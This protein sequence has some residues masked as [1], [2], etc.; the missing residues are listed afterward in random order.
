MVRRPGA[1]SS[2]RGCPSS[3]RWTS[4]ATNGPAVPV[5]PTRSAAW[6]AI[7]LPGCGRTS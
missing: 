2:G 4:S 5:R 3:A 7:S 1:S 6:G